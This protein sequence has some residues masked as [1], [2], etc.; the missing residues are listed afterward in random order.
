MA[1][2]AGPPVRYVLGIHSLSRLR[3]LIQKRFDEITTFFPEVVVN[4]LSVQPE[5]TLS[6][7]IF[8]LIVLPE[9]M[10]ARL[11]FPASHILAR[12]K[13]KTGDSEGKSNK[14]K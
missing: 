6:S 7:I 2:E 14:I 11:W 8:I 1:W 4:K 13:R 3:F 10:G 12:S 5:D 9:G